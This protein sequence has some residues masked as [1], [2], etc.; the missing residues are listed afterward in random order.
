MSKNERKPTYY[1]TEKESNNT[2]KDQSEMYR[3]NTIFLLSEMKNLS[4]KLADIQRSITTINTELKN[5]YSSG[6][7]LIRNDI[8]TFIGSLSPFTYNELTEF[9]KSLETSETYYKDIAKGFPRYSNENF[10]VFY[11]QRFDSLDPTVLNYMKVVSQMTGEK[12]AMYKRLIIKTQQDGLEIPKSFTLLSTLRSICDSRIGSYYLEKYLEK[13][14]DEKYVE[15]YRQVILYNQTTETDIKEWMANE[16]FETFISEISPK[17]ISFSQQVMETINNNFIEQQLNNIFD[18]TKEEVFKH[19]ESIDTFEHFKISLFFDQLSHR[20]AQLPNEFN[21][22]NKKRQSISLFVECEIDTIIAVAK[23]LIPHNLVEYT[24]QFVTNGYTTLSI[25]SKLSEKEIES[26]ALNENDKKRLNE[27]YKAVKENALQPSKTINAEAILKVNKIQKNFIEYLEQKGVVIS[28]TKTF[29]EYI[30]NTPIEQ[31]NVKQTIKHTEKA[32]IELNSRH[33]VAFRQLKKCDNVNE[34]KHILPQCKNGMLSILVENNLTEYNSSNYWKPTRTISSMKSHL[35][36]QSKSPDF[37]SLRKGADAYMSMSNSDGL[38]TQ[39]SFSG[40]M[41]PIKRS[42]SPRNSI[43]NT[44]TLS[45]SK[46]NTITVSTSSPTKTQPNKIDINSTVNQL[47]NSLTTLTTVIEPKLNTLRKSLMSVK[48]KEEYEKVR[49]SSL[50]FENIKKILDTEYVENDEMKEYKLEIDDSS[51]KEK[52]KKDLNE[53]D[54]F[55]Q[56]TSNL[57]QKLNSIIISLKRS[58]EVSNKYSTMI[59][60]LVSTL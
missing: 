10:D 32:F 14:G 37:R 52:V 36:S 18:E 39:Q 51:I 22:P 15:F 4:T 21:A 23:M 17:R 47:E 44:I 41:S 6:S 27:F 50:S 1:K 29:L 48:N 30:E 19:L 60:T 49:Q 2:P 40:S 53:L 9:T 35:R 33:H 3:K 43:D 46:G 11:L 57:S 28:D 13:T 31:L 8:N 5:L 12:S 20:L 38:M 42:F 45:K 59:E 25:I 34:M 24:E 56:S 7:S 55:I 58:L 26:I 16:I 54:A